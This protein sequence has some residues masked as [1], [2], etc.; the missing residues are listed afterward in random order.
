MHYGGQIGDAPNLIRLAGE[1]ASLRMVE[2]AAPR[3]PGK[4]RD[5]E[6]ARWQGLRSFFDVFCFSFC[7][8]KCLT[9]DE[10]DMACTDVA[11][12][13]DHIRMISLHGISRDTWNRFTAEGFGYY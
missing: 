11:E 12:Y 5:S 4:Y 6:A 2:D 1:G 13:A 9:T 8:N 3:C 10:G 7:A